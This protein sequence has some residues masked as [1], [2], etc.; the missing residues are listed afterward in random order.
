MT[1]ERA[2]K[3][4]AQFRHVIDGL[5]R[6]EDDAESCNDSELDDDGDDAHR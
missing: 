6:R 2:Q 1:I 5:A 3:P 4:L